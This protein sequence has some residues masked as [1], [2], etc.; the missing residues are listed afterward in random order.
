VGQNIPTNTN[1]I[2]GGGK[3]T[4]K[5][6]DRYLLAG[7]GQVSV[8]LGNLEMFIKPNLVDNP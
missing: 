3:I 2:D 7:D 1:N 5:R 4:N 6:E 8:Q